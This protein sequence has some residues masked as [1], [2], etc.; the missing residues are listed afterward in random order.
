MD[1]T[2]GKALILNR[3]P[4]QEWFDPDEAA[5]AS[6][7]SPSFI[8]SRITDGTI[9]AQSFRKRG[10]D[11]TV[12]VHRTNRI[13]V[14]DL[15]IFIM[16]NGQGRYEEKKSFSD[17]IAV[18]RNWPLWMLRELYK[19]LGKIIEHRSARLVSNQPKSRA[20]SK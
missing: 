16:L 6:G 9:P 8:K 13:H 17:L 3:L 5:A 10:E 18:I 14:D 11:P 15:V 20:P 4:S 12:R 2:P 7:W 1:Y 19:A